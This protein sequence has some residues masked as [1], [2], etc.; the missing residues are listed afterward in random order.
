MSALRESVARVRGAV[1]ISVALLAAFALVA[2][3]GFAP[4]LN[5]VDL[6][7]GSGRSVVLGRYAGRPLP[8]VEAELRQAGLQVTTRTAFSLREPRGTVVAQQP[9]AGTRVRAGGS[10]ELVVSR[11]ASR[12]TMPDVVGQPLDAA[13]APLDEAGVTVQIDRRADERL[14]AGLVLEQ[15]PG[16]GRE[17]TGD[18]VARLVVS[19][20]PA[21][22]PVPDVSGRTLV[23]A[24]YVLGVFGMAVADVVTTRDTDL[25][26]GAVVGTEP[27]A[28]T[29]VARDTPLKVVVAGPGAAV[30][31]PPLTGL[32]VTAAR[33]RL[34]ADGFV[35]NVL[36]AT[37]AEATA[38][39]ATLPSPRPSNPPSSLTPSPSLS[40]STVPPAL[41]PTAGT[42]L[43]Q[44]PLA[45]QSAL[46]GTVVSLLVAP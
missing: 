11:G 44:F 23:N 6:V 9:L 22:R 33:D 34:T 20:G 25:P 32:S 28:G 46:P 29:V 15:E 38:A 16:P 24:S 12:V 21:P 27:A 4:T 35:P 7:T 31:L 5:P 14:A 40:P 37:R 10:V 19:D 30:I 45:G 42:V 26:D 41:V 36:T 2:L 17:V 8:G 39:A 18:A 3:L 13:R 43:S 1:P